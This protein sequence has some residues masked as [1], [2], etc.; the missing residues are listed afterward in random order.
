MHLN[1]NRSSRRIISCPARHLVATACFR[2]IDIFNSDLPLTTPHVIP[3]ALHGGRFETY[4]YRSRVTHI[5]CNN[6]PDTK[7]KQLAHAR[8]AAAGCPA[9]QQQLAAGHVMP[10]Q[11]FAS[12]ALTAA[13]AAITIPL[14]RVLL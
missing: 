9:D 4:Y 5:I 2:L 3:Q 7:L 1:S 12:V 6:L 10:L 13:L 14:S 8:C 11:D